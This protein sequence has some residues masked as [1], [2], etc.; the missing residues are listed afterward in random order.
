MKV[1]VSGVLSLLVLVADIWAIVHVIQSRAS[2]LKKVLWIV[3]ILLL[4]VLGVI[5]WFF[6]GPR[7]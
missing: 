2:V 5:A 3:A 7:G 1:E 6:F 4:P